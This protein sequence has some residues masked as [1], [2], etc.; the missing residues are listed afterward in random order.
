VVS[1]PSVLMPLPIASAIYRAWVGRYRR[2]P[3]FFIAG[4]AGNDGRIAF[5]TLVLTQS[6]AVL[7][8]VTL[9]ALTWQQTQIWHNS[10][11]LWRHALAVD[12]RSNFA[13]NNL[14]LTLAE[15]GEF[16]EAIN[17]IRRAVQIDPRFVAAQT[18]L[19]NFLGQGDSPRWR[20]PICARL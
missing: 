8:L 17:H 18:N 16:A 15:R 6:F 4:E 1:L 2:E 9:A 7:L 19:G 3:G 14:G 11:R 13:H 20:S 10:E 5:S 12:E